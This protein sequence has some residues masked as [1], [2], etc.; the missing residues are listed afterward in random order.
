MKREATLTRPFY[1]WVYYKTKKQF[2]KNPLIMNSR[3][4]KIFGQ[5][6]YLSHKNVYAMISPSLARQTMIS[7]SVSGQ[8][9]SVDVTYDLPLRMPVSAVRRIN[10]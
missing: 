10:E 3:W 5:F 6:Y 2:I 9:F 7:Y 1:K 4:C 8:V